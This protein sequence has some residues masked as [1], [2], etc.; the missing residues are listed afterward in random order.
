MKEITLPYPCI[1]NYMASTIA[2][3]LSAYY[4]SETFYV[5]ENHKLSYLVHHE[6][7]KKNKLVETWK[8]G[9]RYENNI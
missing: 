1:T 4:T 5:Y 3:K 7:Q 9:E 8:R 2:Q 6:V